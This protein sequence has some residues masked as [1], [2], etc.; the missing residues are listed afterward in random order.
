MTEADGAR[1]PRTR[2]RRE[3]SASESLLSIALL[4]EAVLVFFVVM[5]AFGLQ[6]LPTP[7]VFGGGAL[8]VVL[9][10]VA[11]RL[12]GRA[13]GVWLGWALQVVLIALGILL[14]LMYFIGAIF[15][16]IW[17]YCFVTG[18]RL[19]RR[20]AAYLLDNSSTPNN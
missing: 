17:I 9:L 7:V 2:V 15:A 12:A 4:L 13:L 19:D 11:G 10:V 16:A 14:P 6:V 20:K 18:R 3:R 1:P 8:L 5:V